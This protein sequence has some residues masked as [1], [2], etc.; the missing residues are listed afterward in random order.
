[1]ILPNNMLSTLQIDMK[2]DFIGEIFQH[3]TILG[4]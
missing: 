1:M 4:W 3:E 2:N